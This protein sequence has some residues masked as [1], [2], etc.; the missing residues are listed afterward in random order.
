MDAWEPGLQ[1]KG[2]NEGFSRLL[3]AQQ[4][5]W[6]GSPGTFPGFKELGLGLRSPEEPVKGISAGALRNVR[7]RRESEGGIF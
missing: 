3:A 7:I 5:V 1:L 6:D 2:T 4:N